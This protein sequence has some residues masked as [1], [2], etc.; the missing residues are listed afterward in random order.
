MSVQG[1]KP[2]M[3]RLGILGASNIAAKVLPAIRRV[4][5]IEVVSIASQRDS[6]SLQFSKNHSIPS[7]HASYQ[8]LLSDSGVDAVYITNLSAD[9]ARTVEKALRAGKHVLCEKPL[10]LKGAEAENLFSIARAN[11]LVLLEG[12][13]YRFHPQIIR[14][15]E[16]I[17]SGAIGE[18][19]SIRGTFSFILHDLEKR[20]GRMT[21]A[22]GGGAL[23]DIGCYLVDFVNSI[24][25]GRSVSGQDSKIPSHGCG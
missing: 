18:V 12:F 22:A 17:N 16:I 5:E 7:Q 23:N 15:K 2:G 11:G 4:P 10:A 3:I 6:A 8:A 25:G 24:V 21:S 1:H 19:R 14:L 20:P 13:M 9:H